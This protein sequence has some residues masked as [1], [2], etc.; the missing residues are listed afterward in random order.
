MENAE[1]A[2]EVQIAELDA[3][4]PLQKAASESARPQGPGEARVAATLES[5]PAIRLSVEG[6]ELVWED[7]SKGKA[8]FRLESSHDGAHFALA[9]E[10]PAGVTRYRPRPK[11]PSTTEFYRIF[12]AMGGRH[13][14]RAS[15]VVVIHLERNPA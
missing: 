10:I 8:G 13:S 9:A 6:E 12:Y 7:E 3:S 4:A 11:P 15:N 5:A 14:A 1:A 2:A